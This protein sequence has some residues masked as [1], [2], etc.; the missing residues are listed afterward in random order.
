MSLFKKK[1]LE[2]KYAS[3]AESGR[4]GKIIKAAFTASTYDER[5]AA[6]VSL[7]EIR[8]KESVDTLLK[9]IKDDDGE[10]RMA[11]ATALKKVGTTREVEALMHYAEIEKDPAIAE[12]MKE[13]AVA[14]RDRT[15]R[16]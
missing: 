10:V 6:L 12:A 5:C 2:E 3:L 9:A 13:A 11:C 15:P 7:G 16:W 8:A 4:I 1:T 14:S